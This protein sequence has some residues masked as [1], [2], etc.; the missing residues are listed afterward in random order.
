M[1]CV[2][3]PVVVSLCLFG[4]LG[5][6]YVDHIL[7]N[8]ILY[9]VTIG[10]GCGAL[11]ARDIVNRT[12]QVS[13]SFNSSFDESHA[14]LNSSN[15]WC[16]A[17]LNTLQYLIIHLG[18]KSNASRSDKNYFSSCIRALICTAGVLVS[19]CDRTTYHALLIH[20]RKEWSNVFVLD[21]SVS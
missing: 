6:H 9:C 3:C 1:L 14:L 19:N 4:R 10:P 12:I 21:M 15:A 7:I 8:S 17:T 18:K 16:S 13:G 20:T 5:F 11:L 2:I